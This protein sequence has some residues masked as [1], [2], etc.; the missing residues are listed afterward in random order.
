M[1][2]TRA[3]ASVHDDAATPQTPLPMPSMAVPGLGRRFLHV[4]L[5]L[6]CY[7]CPHARS[8]QIYEHTCMRS[9]AAA[10]AALHLQLLRP[11]FTCSCSGRTLHRGI[12]LAGVSPCPPLSSCPVRVS[13]MHTEMQLSE[14][15]FQVVYPLGLWSRSSGVVKVQFG[16]G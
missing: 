14:G 3:V 2:M 9:A 5:P 11:P 15:G 1:H 6:E 16:Y 10:T 13:R 4:T 7:T 8:W 12:R